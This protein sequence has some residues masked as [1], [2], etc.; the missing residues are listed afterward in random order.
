MARLTIVACSRLN[1]EGS[2]EANPFN[3]VAPWEAHVEKGL[4]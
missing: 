4:E 3:F 2:K 1:I